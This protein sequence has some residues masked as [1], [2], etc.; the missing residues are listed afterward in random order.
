MREA[1]I[2]VTLSAAQP[3]CGPEFVELAGVTPDHRPKSV[4]RTGIETIGWFV[5]L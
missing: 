2:P 3:A 1:D 4:H 5:P